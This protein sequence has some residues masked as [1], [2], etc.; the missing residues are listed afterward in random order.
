MR[1]HPPPQ[2]TTI[3]MATTH[4]PPTPSPRQLNISTFATQNTRGLCRLPQDTNGKLI[5]TKP[6]DYTRYEHL[7]GMMKT[8]SIDVYFVQEAWLEGDV[9]NEVINGYHIFRH[10]GGKGNHNFHGVTIILSLQYYQGW[11]A[12]G[13]RPPLTTDATDEFAGQYISINI[14]LKSC[15][16]MGKHVRRKKWNKHLAFTFATVY[17]PCTKTGSDGIYACFLDTLNTLLSKL[18]SDNENIMR[19]D[20]N[21]NIGKFDDL[22]SSK[23]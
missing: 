14:I 5:T 18:P 9:F 19:A 12:S 7:I 22:Q 15:D 17:H 23:F 3:A 1:C 21:A 11:K 6:Y 4:H 20:V 13:A 8:K 16:R 10:N 2:P